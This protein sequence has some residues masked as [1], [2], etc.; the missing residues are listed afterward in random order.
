MQTSKG[1]WKPCSLYILQKSG[2][3]LDLYL[4]YYDR[5]RFRQIHTSN[6][7]FEILIFNLFTSEN[8]FIDSLVVRF[9]YI[10][11]FKFILVNVID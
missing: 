11:G 2:N 4:N 9:K 3:F 1:S 6:M 5:R 8:R 7:I 10:E